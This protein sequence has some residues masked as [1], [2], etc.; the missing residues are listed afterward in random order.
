MKNEERFI[1]SIEKFIDLIGNYR[2]LRA[3]KNLEEEY[4]ECGNLFDDFNGNS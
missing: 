4:S 3:N 1:D 2:V